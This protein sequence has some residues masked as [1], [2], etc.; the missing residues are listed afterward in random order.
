M[1]VTHPSVIFLKIDGDK[2]RDV[3]AKFN[4]EGFPT[5]LL[6]RNQQVV[7]KVVGYAPKDIE[8][9]IE[10]KMEMEMDVVYA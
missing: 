7:D 9:K 2:A 10:G 5:V 3:S 4:V 6:I 8:D 1:S